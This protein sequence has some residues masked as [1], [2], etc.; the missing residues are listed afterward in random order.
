MLWSRFFFDDS[1]FTISVTTAGTGIFVA[2]AITTD[3]ILTK[4]LFQQIRQSQIVAASVV[5]TSSI[6]IPA[7]LQKI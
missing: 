2:K 3:L 4:T 1:D 7:A 5:N 6:R